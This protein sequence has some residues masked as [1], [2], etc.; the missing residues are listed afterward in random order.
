MDFEPKKIAAEPKKIAAAMP[1]GSLDAMTV[2]REVKK[3]IEEYVR[4]AI[5][6]R[7]RRAEI[8]A[9]AEVAISHIRA[10][11]DVLVTYLK[12][13]HDERAENFYRLFNALDVAL[14]KDEPT[15]V[16]RFLDEITALANKSPFADLNDV[17]SAREFLAKG[18][19]IEF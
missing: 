17:E 10:R 6:E 8:H 3:A 9:Q 13:A 1:T 4:V 14:A 19:V 7:T 15:E 5:E 11:R 2:F 12:F 18:G 16:G